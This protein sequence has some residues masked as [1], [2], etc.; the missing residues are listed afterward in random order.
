MAHWLSI[1]AAPPAAAGRGP[2]RFFVNVGKDRQESAFGR[3]GEWPSTTL[4]CRRLTEWAGH[5][6]VGL[7][8]EV[9][10]V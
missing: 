4:S 2:C 1:A 9:D 8:C 3:E 6:P 5:I 7:W 10:A